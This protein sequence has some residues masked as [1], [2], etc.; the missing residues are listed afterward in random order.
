MKLPSMTTIP[1][2]GCTAGRVNLEGLHVGRY[3]ELVGPLDVDTVRDPVPRVEMD[4]ETAGEPCMNG[5][6][7]GAQPTGE[8]REVVDQPACQE[9]LPGAAASG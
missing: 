6:G 3:Q 8:L 5:F 4:G 1:T 9:S 2:P 7:Q